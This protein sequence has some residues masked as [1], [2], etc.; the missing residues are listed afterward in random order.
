MRDRIDCG[1]ILEQLMQHLDLDE[2]DMEIFG[3]TELMPT[4]MKQKGRQPSILNRVVNVDLHKLSSG[5][6]MAKYGDQQNLPF[7]SLEKFGILG[8]LLGSENQVR[9]IAP[10][11]I[12]LCLGCSEMTVIPRNNLLRWR[13]FGNAIHEFH[14]LVGLITAWNFKPPKVD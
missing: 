11:E 7:T 10:I 12:L 6:A 14:A 8:E 3:L 4:S 13:I 9:F 1:S 2:K 5:T